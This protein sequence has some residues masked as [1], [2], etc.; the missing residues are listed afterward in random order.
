[1]D[2]LSSP[3]FFTRNFEASPPPQPHFKGKPFQIFRFYATTGVRGY[4]FE[5]KIKKKTFGLVFKTITR[6]GRFSV[7]EMSIET[8]S[9]YRVRHPSNKKHLNV[10]NCL[11]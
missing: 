7:L 11:L 8:N 3:V 5:K 6:G 1:M 9:S 4:L 10:K 2:T